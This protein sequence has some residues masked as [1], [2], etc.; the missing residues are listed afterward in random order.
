MEAHISI[1]TAHKRLRN[2]GYRVTKQRAAIYEYLLSTDVHPTA[3]TIHHSVRRP[4]ALYQP[5][6]RLQGSGLTHR[7]RT[8]QPS[9]ARGL[10]D[11]LRCQR[12]RPR[13]L[14][15]SLLRR[16]LGRPTRRRVARDSGGLRSR[17]RQ[18]RIRRLLR[19]MPP[20]KTRIGAVRHIAS[21]PV[22]FIQTINPAQ[23]GLYP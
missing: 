13:P 18:C 1:E 23:C 11:P 15:L 10:V 16:P 12:R 20:Q 9:P 21:Q 6:D 22:V 5:S 17:P 8:D 14:P 3:E 7:C 19:R 4:I 2:A